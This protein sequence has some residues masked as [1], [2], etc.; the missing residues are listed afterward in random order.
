MESVAGAIL[1]LA[2]HKGYQEILTGEVRCPPAAKKLV[3]GKDDAEDL[4]IKARKMNGA[5]Y[6]A[7]VLSSTDYFS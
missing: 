2:C 5:A 1:A 7:L 3:A 4:L 6:S